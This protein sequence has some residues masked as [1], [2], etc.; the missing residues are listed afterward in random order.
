MGITKRH[1]KAVIQIR[2]ATEAEWIEYD[3]ILHLGEPALSTDVYKVK[4]GD[5]KSCW[6]K[7][8]YLGEREYNI[9]LYWL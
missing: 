5:G 1:V 3:P 2:R 9:N 4:L 8:D 7:L 6:S